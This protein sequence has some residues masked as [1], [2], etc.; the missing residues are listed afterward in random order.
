MR[1][2]AHALTGALQEAKTARDRDSFGA[3]PLFRYRPEGTAVAVLLSHQL[4]Q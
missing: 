3:L 2:G 1:P 4:L